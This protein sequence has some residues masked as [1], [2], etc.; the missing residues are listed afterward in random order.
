MSLKRAVNGFNDGKSVGIEGLE[1]LK[2]ARYTK[3]TIR[4]PK[5]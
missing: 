4:N 2:A 5:R 3:T 1:R